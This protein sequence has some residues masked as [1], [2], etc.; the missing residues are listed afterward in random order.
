MPRT[1]LAMSHP[2]DLAGHCRLAT[3][4]GD[5]PCIH[6]AN[7]LA[8]AEIHLNGGHVA[9]YQP[10]ND[11]RPVLWTS[12]RS[13]WEAGQP[14]RG[15]IPVCWP[16]FGD[17]GPE[18][19]PA[20]GIARTARWHWLGAS[21][22]ADGGTRI[23]L[24]LEDEAGARRW[25]LHPFSLRLVLGV[26]HALD[27]ALQVRNRAAEAVTWT[28]ALHSYFAVSDARAVRVEGLEGCSYIDRLDHDAVKLQTGPVRFRAET[29]R[30]YRD[31]GATAWIVDEGWKRRI[32]VTKRGSGST[33]VWNPWVAKSARMPDFGD[34]EWTGMCCVETAR[35]GEDACTLGPGEG[36][37]LGV[38]IAVD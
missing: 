22:L 23:E 25:W 17:S 16:W 26:G 31:S 32:A 19:A 12:G 27:V 7:D 30:I 15:G 20:H 3:G 2:L 8:A 24:G 11:A 33:V 34:D 1:I 10:R 38:T 21:A 36:H 5:L 28:G 35:A 29:D 14:I 37:E 18:G 13:H 9:H 6:V 4:P